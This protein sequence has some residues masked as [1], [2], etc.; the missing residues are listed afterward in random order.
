M[1][2]P[3]YVAIPAGTAVLMAVLVDERLYKKKFVIIVVDVIVWRV[4]TYRLT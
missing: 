1:R 2:I 4:T 3:G